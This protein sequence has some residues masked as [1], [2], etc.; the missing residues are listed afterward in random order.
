MKT[1]MKTDRQTLD[2]ITKKIIGCAYKISNTLGCGFLE[3]V[4]ENALIIELKKEGLFAQQQVPLKVQYDDE[5]VGEYYADIIVETMILVELKTVKKLEDIHFAQ[6][7]NY[8]HAT[9]LKVCLLLNFG[10]TK[11]EIKRIVN[12]F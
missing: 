2:N 4:Y 3:K 7:L 1:Q 12:K 9:N 8:L 11:V 10:K 6:C 5:I